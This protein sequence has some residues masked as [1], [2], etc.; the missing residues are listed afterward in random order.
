[1]N[2]SR[3]DGSGPCR[4]LVVDSNEELARALCYAIDTESDIV[5]VG[6]CCSGKEALLKARASAADIMLLDFNLSDRNAL[7]VL[8]EAKETAATVGIIVFTG[9]ALPELACEARAHG[10][11]G[12]V[13]KGIAFD[14]LVKE[15]MRIFAERAATIA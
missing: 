9:H 11:A 4:V 1:M 2:N 15:I 14:D 7:A 8:D 3:L 12:F 13:V 10:A 5:S 6:F